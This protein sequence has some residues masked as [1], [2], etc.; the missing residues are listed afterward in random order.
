MLGSWHA[1]LWYAVLKQ[2]A[3]TL[4]LFCKLALKFSL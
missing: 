4:R 2:L 3:P 1:Q